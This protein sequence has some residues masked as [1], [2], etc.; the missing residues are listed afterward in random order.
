MRPRAVKKSI[1]ATARL[2][3]VGA[4]DGVPGEDAGGG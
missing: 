4:A 3:D 1:S 2:S